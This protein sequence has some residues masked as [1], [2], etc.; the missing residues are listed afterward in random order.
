MLNVA[1]KNSTGGIELFQMNGEQLEFPIN[2]FDYVVLSHVIAVA[3]QPEKLLS[4]CYNVL[5]SNGK[6]LILNHFTPN[7]WPEIYG[8]DIQF[9]FWIIP[10]KIFIL[11]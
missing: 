7:N 6:L 2:S 4:Q 11:H 10:F 5:K 9:R 3:D 1:K 8:S